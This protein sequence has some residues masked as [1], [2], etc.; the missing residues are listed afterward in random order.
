MAPKVEAAISLL[1]MVERLDHFQRIEK[2]VNGL[3]GTRSQQVKRK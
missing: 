3:A 2:V 1:T